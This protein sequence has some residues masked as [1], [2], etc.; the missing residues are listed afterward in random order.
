MFKKWKLLWFYIKTLKKHTQDIRNHFLQNSHQTTYQI[1]DMNFDRV[2]RFYTVL[3]LPPDTAENIQRYGYHYMDNET[4]KFIKELN[5][6]FKQYGL[7]ELV[8]LSK[9]DQIGPTNILVVVEFKLMKTTKIAK[10]LM[11]L[12]L[13]LLTVGIIFVIL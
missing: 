6:Q 13:L 8:G 12:L 2:Y 1:K 9:A 7:M 10:N 5:T 3:N 11:L 4:K